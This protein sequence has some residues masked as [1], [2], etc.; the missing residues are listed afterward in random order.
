MTLLPYAV[1]NEKG[2]TTFHLTNRQKNSLTPKPLQGKGN[3]RQEIVPTNT[4]DEIVAEI[5]VDIPNL[6]IITVNGVE[7]EA[8]Q[9][10]E[11]ILDEGTNLVIAAKYIINGTPTYQLVTT[12]LE[13]KGYN[14]ILDHYGFT[15]N[16]SPENHAVIYAS[17]KLSDPK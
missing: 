5:G 9:G 3:I 15:K 2:F 17:Q 4:I 10:M 8:L 13:K 12:L 14:F 6:V 16:E 1:W 11:R 7:V